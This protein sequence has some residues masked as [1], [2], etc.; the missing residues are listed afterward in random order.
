MGVVVA[1]ALAAFIGAG[2]GTAGGIAIAVRVYLPRL[3]ATVPPPPS[4]SQ[5]RPAWAPEPVEDKYPGSVVVSGV[6]FNRSRRSPQT[7]PQK[8]Y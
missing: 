1:A 7:G 3:R 2:A 5:E 6:Q 4:A 8:P